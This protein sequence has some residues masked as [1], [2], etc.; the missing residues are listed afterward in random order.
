VAEAAEALRRLLADGRII[1]SPNSQRGVVKGRVQLKEL[2][3]HVLQL[4]G[5]Q[6]NTRLGN[7]RLSGR[8]AGVSTLL[9]S[10]PR[11]KKSMIFGPCH[12]CLTTPR[13]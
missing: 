11:L 10:I 5:W 2:G 13:G 3:D 9:M 7:E 6:R 8:G 12:V 1:L 4:A